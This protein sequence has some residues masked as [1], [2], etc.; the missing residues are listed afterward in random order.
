MDWIFAFC[1]LI[2]ALACFSA[3]AHRQTTKAHAAFTR[4]DVIAAIENVL[5]LNIEPGESNLHDE[6]DLFLAWPIDDPYLESIRQKCFA[7][8]VEYSGVEKGKD[9]GSRGEAQLRL[10]LDELKNHA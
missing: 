10:I 9:I 5:D 6:W 2:V 3:W 4:Y 8:F 7:I 1:L